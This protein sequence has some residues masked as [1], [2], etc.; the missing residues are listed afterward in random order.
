MTVQEWTTDRLVDELYLNLMSVRKGFTRKYQTQA[1][2]LMYKIPVHR[3]IPAFRVEKSDLS[4][5]IKSEL[6]SLGDKTLDRVM[7]EGIG[8]IFEVIDEIYFLLSVKRLLKW[9]IV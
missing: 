3:P 4:D 1:E 9:E 6:R 7:K 8:K 5:R 2:D